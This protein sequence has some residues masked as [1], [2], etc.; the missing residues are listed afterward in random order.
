MAC[1]P[2][3]M[4]EGG[5]VLDSQTGGIIRSDEV[6]DRRLG[7]GSVWHLDKAKAPR[8]AR[9]SIRDNLGAVDDAIRFEQPFQF[10][11]RGGKGQ[12]PDK[13]THGA[14]LYSGTSY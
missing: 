4:V 13:N 3:L 6:H 12:I 9:L 14:F 7:L 8:A 11:F 1:P 10:F 2:S 5:I